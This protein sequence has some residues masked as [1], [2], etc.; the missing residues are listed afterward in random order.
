MLLLVCT[1]THTHTHNTDMILQCLLRPPQEDKAA[2]MFTSSMEFA[3]VLFPVKMVFVI[4]WFGLLV[5]V[6]FQ[7]TILR[8]YGEDFDIDIENTPVP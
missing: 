3:Y 2:I 8:S 4:C 5:K 6:V 1:H 7:K